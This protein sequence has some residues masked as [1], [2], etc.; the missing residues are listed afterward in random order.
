MGQVF[1]YNIIMNLL[2]FAILSFG[3]LFVIV[4]PITLAPTFLAMTHGDDPRERVRM[5]ATASVI[6]F[7]ILALFSIFGQWI[8][9]AFGITLPAFQIAGGIILLKIALDMLQAK[10]TAVKETPEEKLEGTDKDDIAITPLAIPMLAGPGAITA[11]TLLA[12]KA[13]TLQHQ[14]IL[15]ANIFIVSSL[16]FL[17][18][19]FFSLRSIKNTIVLKVFTRLMGLLLAAIS[20]QFIL[21]GIETSLGI[22]GAR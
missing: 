12:S 15:F 6:T 3:S 7:F 14:V 9:K 20:V 1:V 4:D 19:V 2:D 17:L 13:A 18:L 16:S 8:F 11:V 10:R 21:N 5:A 22:A